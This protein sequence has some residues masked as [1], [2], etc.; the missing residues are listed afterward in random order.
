MCPQHQLL[1]VPIGGQPLVL[2]H[3]ARL[4]FL[5]G[6]VKIVARNYSLCQRGEEKKKFSKSSFLTFLKIN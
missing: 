4:D 5:V 3:C 2:L 6:A 1:W